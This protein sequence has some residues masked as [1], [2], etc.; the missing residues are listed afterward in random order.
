M[1]SRRNQYGFS[2]IIRDLPLGIDRDYLASYLRQE[3]NVLSVKIEGSI[4]FVSVDSEYSAN[5]IINK[6]NYSRFNDKP[7]RI[8]KYDDKTRQIF[9]EGIGVVIVR[10]LPN[11]IE[12][13]EVHHFFSRVGEVIAVQ[14][15]QTD[16]GNLG[17][18]FVQYRDNK[19]GFKASAELTGF[20]V[21]E[22]KIVVEPI[23]LNGNISK[24][25]KPKDIVIQEPK[26]APITAK[27]GIT[28]NG[29]ASK[30]IQ[31]NGIIPDDKKIDI[32]LPQKRSSNQNYQQNVSLKLGRKEFTI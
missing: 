15:P 1:F 31:T 26:R 6:L 18:A 17:F 27:F 12:I 5:S 13:S 16:W 8:I 23:K 14:I 19:T 29:V 24:V 2:L 9:A 7:I 3:G 32:V 22:N 11:E 25:H 21:G 30:T 20:R 28:Q 4:A 10:G